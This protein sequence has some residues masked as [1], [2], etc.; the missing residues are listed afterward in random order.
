M[1]EICTC[2]HITHLQMLNTICVISLIEH[3]AYF[4]SY[5]IMAYFINEINYAYPLGQYLE[6]SS[7]EGYSFDCIKSM[8]KFLC[9]PEI[10]PWGIMLKLN[11]GLDGVDRSCLCLLT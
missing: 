4:D 2:T 10:G 1:L 3:C 7:V 8:A 5:S 11:I 9:I 6:N